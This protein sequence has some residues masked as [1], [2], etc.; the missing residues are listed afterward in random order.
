MAQRYVLYPGPVT[1][2]K[3]GQ[4]HF[5]GASTLARL[6][7][8]EMLDCVVFDPDPYNR[9]EDYT[10]CIHLYP[11]YDEECMQPQVVAFRAEQSSDTSMHVE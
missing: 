6:Y 7:G 11:Q 4:S 10:E 8:I 3:N 2:R 1:C 9:T 5:V